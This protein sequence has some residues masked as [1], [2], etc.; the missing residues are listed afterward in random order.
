MLSYRPSNAPPHTNTSPLE[1]T[2]RVSPPAQTGSTNGKAS[3]SITVS[4]AS[5]ARMPAVW[6][7]PPMWVRILSIS[8][9]NT[10]P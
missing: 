6:F 9:T 7:W 10:R 4:R 5:W 2:M 1:S 8:S 3:F